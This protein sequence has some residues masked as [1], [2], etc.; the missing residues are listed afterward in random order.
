[1]RDP[2]ERSKGGHALTED[3]VRE[4]ETLYFAHSSELKTCLKRQKGERHFGT[5]TWYLEAGGV[6]GSSPGQNQNWVQMM[7][8]DVT[9]DPDLSHTQ[10]RDKNGCI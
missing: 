7:D 1:M 4:I 2:E 6:G 9:S 3:V 10:A 5:A 8:L